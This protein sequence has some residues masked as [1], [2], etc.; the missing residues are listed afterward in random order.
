MFNMFIVLANKHDVMCVDNVRDVATVAAGLPTE[1][2]NHAE[3][4]MDVALDMKDAA[5]FVIK[6]GGGNV[7]VR[8]SAYSGKVRDAKIWQGTTNKIIVTLHT[9]QLLCLMT[10][11]RREGGVIMRH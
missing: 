8:V 7:Q 5:A 9:H 2:K 10:Q 6:P 3:K 1:I 11:N 4:A